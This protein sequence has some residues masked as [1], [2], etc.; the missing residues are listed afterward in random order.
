MK[1]KKPFSEF[2]TDLGKSKPQAKRKKM[3]KEEII[4]MAENIRIRHLTNKGK[5]KK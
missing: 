1:D 2:M 4:E 5:L 3:T